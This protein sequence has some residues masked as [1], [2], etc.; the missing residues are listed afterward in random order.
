MRKFILFSIIILA[1]LGAVISYFWFTRNSGQLQ[2]I[3]INSVQEKIGKD[4]IED[5]LLNKVLG[6]DAPRFYLVLFLNNTELR[7]AGGFIGAYAVVKVD[8]GI[9]EILKVEGTEILDN[10]APKDFVSVPPAP[11]GKYLKVSRWNFRDSNWSPDFAVSSAKALELYKKERGLEAE[12][13]SGVIGFTPTV[14]EELLKISGPIK[15]NGVEFDAK[16]FT[17]KLE[18]EVEYNYAKQGIDFSERKKMLYDLTHALFAKLRVDVFLHWS[19]YLALS[20]QMIKEKQIAAY[21]TET[22]IQKFLHNKEWSGEM[23]T[24]QADYLLWVDANLGALKTDVS[25]NRNLQYKIYR[26]ATGQWM[27][28]AAMTFNHQGKFDWRTSQ[29]MDYARLFVPKGS[30][31]L[32]VSGADEVDYPKNHQADLGE[33]LGYTWFGTFAKVYPGK[34]KTLTFKFKLAPTVVEKIQKG[35]YSL[36]VQKQ[37]G[38]IV[39]KLTLDLDFGKKVVSAAPGEVTEYHGDSKY[40]FVTDLS[41]DRAFEV[42]F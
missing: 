21:S 41:A 2:K 29:Y 14:L 33:E 1:A 38:T 36:L 37:L 3:V 20:E 39:P 27:G 13:I 7:P 4:V 42:K 34:N 18:Y 19:K 9:P 25:I 17:E 15:V 8:K 31:L 26:D 30:E 5:N 24:G 35:E 28:E 11:I 6:I 23:Q 10:L 22:E 12:N 16:N 40:N 32:S